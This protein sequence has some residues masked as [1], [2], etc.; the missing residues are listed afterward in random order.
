MKIPDKYKIYKVI[1]DK[2]SAREINLNLIIPDR[3]YS[4]V[5]FWIFYYL[6]V[7]PPEEKSGAF[8]LISIYVILS[9]IFVKNL[10][11]LKSTNMKVIIYIMLN[12]L[13]LLYFGKLLMNDSY[14]VLLF[15]AV[16]Y[17][18]T[19]CAFINDSKIVIS[20]SLKQMIQVLVTII[21]IA[22]TLKYSSNLYIVELI[23]YCSMIYVVFNSFLELMYIKKCN[24]LR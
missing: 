10:K 21:V 5:I 23:F 3:L 6:G 7:I 24:N 12:L 11:N 20:E 8:L 18:I 2:S 19:Y 1:F 17:L 13:L 14:A 16:T 15:S 4:L 22:F 9:V